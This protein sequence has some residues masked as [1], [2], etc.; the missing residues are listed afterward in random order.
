MVNTSASM[1]FIEQEHTLGDSKILDLGD[2]RP[3]IY[4]ISEGCPQRS[5]FLTTHVFAARQIIVCCGVRYLY[6]NLPASASCASRHP[7]YSHGVLRLLDGYVVLERSH[8]TAD[9]R[10]QR[11]DCRAARK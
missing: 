8:R 10:Q 1:R 11:C 6:A 9:R 7:M 5:D 2:S 3:Y 4:Y